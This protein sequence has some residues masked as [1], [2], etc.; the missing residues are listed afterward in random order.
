MLKEP[1]TGR[2]KVGIAGSG[3]LYSFTAPSVSAP[4]N[5]KRSKDQE[6]PF[7]LVQSFGR[8][9]GSVFETILE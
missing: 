2:Y 4:E 7:F 1:S 8:G 9:H 6:K 3:E 5:I